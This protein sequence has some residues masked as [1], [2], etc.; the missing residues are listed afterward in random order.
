MFLITGSSGVLGTA[1]KNL[2]PDSLC[3]SHWDMD[4]TEPLMVSS[5]LQQ[6]GVADSVKTVIHC[7]GLVNKH[8]EK[9]RQKAMTVN[10]LGTMNVAFFCNMVG[11]KMIYISTEYVFRGD[12]GLYGPD[13]ETGPIMYY[14]ETK[15]AG[16]CVTKSLP[17]YLI[18]RA[19]FMPE[20]FPY[21]EAFTDTFSS[22]LPVSEAARQI[23]DLVRDG[24]N[25]VRHVCGERRSIFE[26]AMS[27]GASVR[28]CVS[29]SDLPRPKDS[30]LR[31]R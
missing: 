15:L 28:P 1:I 13:D 27:Q 31:S 3:P 10:V 22:K 20:P 16:E 7:A 11:A 21:E 17:D 30:S 25:G 18:I 2:I 23:V 5:F 29:R 8:C 4:I 14:G 6:Y 9:D 26:Y 12:R 19:S 24:A